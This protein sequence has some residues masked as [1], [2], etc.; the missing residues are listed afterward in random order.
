MNNFDLKISIFRVTS[1]LD[2]WLQQV[3]AID[4]FH[5]NREILQQR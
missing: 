4:L 3:S 5:G 1:R 2:F